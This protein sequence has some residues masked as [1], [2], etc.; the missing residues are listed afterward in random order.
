MD[1]RTSVETARERFYARPSYA[2][3]QL[4]ARSL[5]SRNGNTRGLYLNETLSRAR[6]YD[7]M[8]NIVFARTTKRYAETRGGFNTE[9]ISVSR[10][11]RVRPRAKGEI[12]A[13]SRASL[14]AARRDI[15]DRHGD[16]I[17]FP[18]RVRQTTGVRPARIARRDVRRNNERTKNRSG[19]IW[20][21]RERLVLLSPRE[22]YRGMMFAML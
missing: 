11:A 20:K 21:E 9:R 17:A 4:A 19:F 2:R 13:L 6:R 12:I 5:V 14:G 22:S 16:T 10:C 18:A 3:A 7:R 15:R 1:C 8:N